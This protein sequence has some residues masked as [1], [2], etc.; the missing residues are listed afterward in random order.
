LTGI[1]LYGFGLGIDAGQGYIVSAMFY[2][3]AIGALLINMNTGFAYML[4]A[5]RPIAMETFVAATTFKN[6]MFFGF[7]YF[8]NNWIANDG[9]RSMF[10]VCGSVA[11]GVLATAFPMY[12]YGKKIRA[13]YARHDLL[14]LFHL[15]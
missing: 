11:V 14:E 2:G 4:D 3:F 5:Y 12:I 7:A 13:F 9:P 1:G 8:F 15:K 10:I 6:F